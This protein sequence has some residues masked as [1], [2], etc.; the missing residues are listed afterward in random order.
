V[1]RRS[2]ATTSGVEQQ[3]GMGRSVYHA[4]RT[5]RRD[6]G[7]LSIHLGVLCGGNPV[8]TI[9]KQKGVVLK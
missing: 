3:L 5:S 7:E 6:F 9:S 8:V 2:L 1:W 4:M